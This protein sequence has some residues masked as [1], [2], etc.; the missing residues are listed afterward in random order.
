[1]VADLYHFDEEQDPDPNQSQKSDLRI[2]VKGGIADTDLHQSD[3]ELQLCIPYRYRIRMLYLLLDN[4]DAERKTQ[5]SRL[6]SAADPDPGSDAF[7]TPGPG[8]GI[9]NRFF[10][11]PGFRIPDS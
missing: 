4:L 8:S 2:K 11:N 1:M 7:L 3:G 9:R 5:I 10:P 6:T